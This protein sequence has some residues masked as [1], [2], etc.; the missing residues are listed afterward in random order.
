MKRI[1]YIL[2]ALVLS[3]LF[4]SCKKT[5]TD[6]SS[7]E[8]SETPIESSS[9]KADESKPES[10]TNL[11]DLKEIISNS[12]KKAYLVKTESQITDSSV[13][14]YKM[15][16]SITI[17]DQD[18]LKGSVITNTYTLDNTF[19]L[20]KDTKV[21]T[22]D[23]LDK[24]T[25]FSATLSD[26]YFESIAIS[27]SGLTGEIKKDFVQNYFNSTSVSSDTNITVNIVVSNYVLQSV[28]Y[29]YTLS[30]RII[31]INTTYSYLS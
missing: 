27:T 30:N 13:V 14:V 16:K 6:P 4:V 19:A 1:K 28:S 22:I 15:D 9:S 5:K 8:S 31:T 25:L 12:I 23:N 17:S 24:S 18:T 11:S 10:L 29:S 21:E 26:S 7:S 3:L 20:S 2:F